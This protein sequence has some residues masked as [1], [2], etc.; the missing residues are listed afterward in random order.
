MSWHNFADGARPL[1]MWLLFRP[2]DQRHRS[3]EKSCRSL[4][5]TRCK[6]LVVL[7]VGAAGSL[8]L[9][10]YCRKVSKSSGSSGSGGGGGAGARCSLKWALRCR[11]LNATDERCRWPMCCFDMADGSPAGRLA[12][13]GGL[14]N[15]VVRRA[16]AA[17]VAV[18]TTAIV[19]CFCSAWWQ[20]ADSERMRIGVLRCERFRYDRTDSKDARRHRT[21]QRSSYRYIC[22]RSRRAI[23]PAIWGVWSTIVHAHRTGGKKA[24][25]C[26]PSP[27][28]SGSLF[29]GPLTIT[30][31]CCGRQWQYETRRTS[32][33]YLRL[34]A[35]SRPAAAS[36]RSGQYSYPPAPAL[37]IPPS[38]SS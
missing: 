18:A 13:I 3:R 10:E 34:P 19:H 6:V 1:P 21:W 11:F 15:D 22:M 16:A 7:V 37:W 9:A 25:A 5:R 12:R 2:A 26:G 35:S 32:P 30:P 38:S 17:A 27:A 14:M 29:E 24:E 20:C 8:Q 4:V 28:R 36:L 23:H 31:R 33:V